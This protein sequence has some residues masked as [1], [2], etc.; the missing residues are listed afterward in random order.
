MGQSRHRI[1]GFPSS[2]YRLMTRLIDTRE[3][4]QAIVKFATARGWEQ[5]H[6]P[7]NLAMA[8]TGEVGELVE[9]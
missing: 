3:L 9:I 2:V 7:K 6:S 8:L 1:M 5:F 4:E